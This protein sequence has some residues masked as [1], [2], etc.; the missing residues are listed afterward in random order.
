MKWE[1]LDSSNNIFDWFDLNRIKTDI[2]C[3]ECG[4]WIYRRTDVVLTS[5]SPQYQYEC[6][7]CG[8]I[9]YSAHKR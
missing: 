2:E 9:G 3:P 8:W 5:I 4:S 6:P 1:E 7:I